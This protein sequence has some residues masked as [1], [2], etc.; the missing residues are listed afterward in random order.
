MKPLSLAQ[1]ARQF[2]LV[3]LRAADLKQLSA[4]TVFDGTMIRP[5]V[6]RKPLLGQ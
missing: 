3:R 5:R 6:S 1:S 4:P 2:Q